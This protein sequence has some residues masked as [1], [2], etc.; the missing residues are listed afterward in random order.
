MTTPARPTKFA[1][2]IG[3]YFGPSYAVTL[4]GNAIV[5]EVQE[6]QLATL[7]TSITPSHEEWAAFRAALDQIN[8]W[9]WDREYT[10][11]SVLDGTSWRIELSWGNQT[12]E[13]SG[14]ND[15]PRGFDDFLD[16]IT[17]L[18]GGREFW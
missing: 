3:G 15:Y 2:E 9:T 10:D 14:A 12:V 7:P 4:E 11:L 5:Y 8:V 1:A 13:S 18:I 17:T 16:A 6:H